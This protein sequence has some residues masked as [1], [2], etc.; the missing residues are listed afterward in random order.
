MGVWLLYLAFLISLA[1]SIVGLSCAR[2]SAKVDSDSLRLRWLAAAAV[3]FGGIGIWLMHFISMIGFTVPGSAVRYDLGWMF[4]SAVLAISAVFVGLVIVGRTM[5]L[6]RL[7]LGGLVMGL[8]V[9][10]MHYTG[11]WA[12]RVQGSFVYETNLV[13]ASIVIAVVGSTAA[14]WF[15]LVVDSA[16]VRIAAGFVIALAL[17]GMHMTAMAAVKVRLDPAAPVPSGLDVFSF[18]FPVFVLGLLALAI[19]ITAVMM[20]GT[21]ADADDEHDDFA[22]RADLLA[23]AGMDPS[24]P[25]P[26]AAPGLLGALNRRPI[27][28][29]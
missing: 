7:L 1:G 24:G 26:G 5:I 3:A 27:I 13:V 17:L 20:A 19:L 4:A 23:D 8:G 9:S 11:M 29:S 28:S 2:W 16:T 10:L 25:E 6:P 14:L 12:F 22:A 21:N 18:V 15:T